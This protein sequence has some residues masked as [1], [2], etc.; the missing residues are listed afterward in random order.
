MMIFKK[1]QTIPQGAI[2]ET[3]IGQCRFPYEESIKEIFEILSV[4]F[5]MNVIRVKSFYH[6]S[7]QITVMTFFFRTKTN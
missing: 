5:H 2:T 6:N 7:K 1:T 3:Y 4:G